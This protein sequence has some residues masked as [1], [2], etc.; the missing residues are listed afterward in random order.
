MANPPINISSL[1]FSSIKQS[2]KSYLTTQSEFSSY[3]FEGTA[4]ST[5]LDVMAY[6]T[7]YYAFYSNMIANETFLN[8]AQLENSVVSLLKPLGFLV[9]GN[10]ASKFTV[11]LTGTQTIT[12]FS[13]VFYGYDPSGNRY[14]F[15]SIEEYQLT[16]VPTE[17]TV[18]EARSVTKDKSINDQNS[19]DKI[20]L[21]EQKYFLGNFDIDINTLKV[22]VDGVEWTFYNNY[23]QNNPEDDKIYFIDRTSDGFYLLFGK[24]TINDLMGSFGK[25]II[26]TNSVT[27]S[28]ITPNGDIANGLAFS[29]PIGT[30]VSSGPSFGGGKP[31]LDL[32]RTFAP[33]LFASLDR[34]VTKDDYYAIIASSGI[35]PKNIETANQIQVWGG[36]ELNYPIDGRVFYSLANP[37][38]LPDNVKGITSLLKRKSVVS[39]VPE[40]VQSEILDLSVN[41]RITGS[42]RT[43][44]IA[45]DIRSYYNTGIEFNKTFSL[46]ETIDALRVKYGFG[47]GARLTNIII[48]DCRFNVSLKRGTGNRYKFFG[49]PFK[50]LLTTDIV[51]V[52]SVLNSQAFNYNNEIVFIADKPETTKSDEWITGLLNMYNA[53]TG[54]IIAEN[55]GSINYTDGWFY[56]DSTYLPTNNDSV[57]FNIICKDSTNPIITAGFENIL[58]VSPAVIKS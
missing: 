27:I 10:N 53:T 17:V 57:L 7:L 39:I 50:T 40:Y 16:S 51:G 3:N 30:V 23:N 15:Y 37:D 58:S 31:D 47:T 46:A 5:L 55:I 19:S 41:F 56:L 1:D 54:S 38:L 35:L 25:T 21:T 11:S 12:P 28:F 9:N 49:N 8:T 2:L 22:K 14:T 43:T 4:L 26:A 24:K 6:N 20:N 33:K 32:I 36:D 13:T 34:A 52:G 42:A 45:N 29:S 48:T 18:Y 44:D